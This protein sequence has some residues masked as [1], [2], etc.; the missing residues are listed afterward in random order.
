[1]GRDKGLG[2]LNVIRTLI[3]RD[4]GSEHHASIDE[5]G[6]S[7][8]GA[9]VRATPIAPGEVRVGEGAGRTAWVASAGDVRWVHLDG[10]VYEIEVT[11]AGVRRRAGSGHG[12]LTAPMPATVIRVDVSPGSIVRRGDTLLILE[13]MKM[14]LPVRA[15]GDG[16]VTAVHCRA[17]DLVQPGVSL[18]EVE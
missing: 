8:D 1:M 18:V 14:E 9:A 13:A 7:I 4:G 16:T 17:G 15:T 2:A 11:R 10:N 5:Q 3:L 6:V 12:S